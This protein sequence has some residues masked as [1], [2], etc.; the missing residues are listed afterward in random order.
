MRRMT[1]LFPLLLVVSSTVGRAEVP[2]P[3]EAASPALPPDVLVG[4]DGLTLVPSTWP[5]VTPTATRLICRG[6]ECFKTIAEHPWLS[7]LLAS[8]ALPTSATT[9]RPP[10]RRVELGEGCRGD[11]TPPSAPTPSASSAPAPAA[12]ARRR[13]PVPLAVR[14]AAME[15]TR[16]VSTVPDRDAPT[17]DAT[18]AE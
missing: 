5:P 7:T 14:L 16:R 4:E 18:V 11:L 1:L 12:R 8:E 13:A 2:T 17:T 6:A 9:P 10:A 15:T 3:N